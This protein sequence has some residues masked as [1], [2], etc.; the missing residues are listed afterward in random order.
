VHME[1]LSKRFRRTS[2]FSLFLTAMVLSFG[3]NLTSDP[4]TRALS[5]FSA[6]M[7]QSI[8]R[9]STGKRL[10]FS[11]DNPSGVASALNLS[12][13]LRRY[14]AIKDGVAN[15]AGLVQVQIGALTDIHRLLTRAEV[16]AI[17]NKSPFRWQYQAPSKG[18][19]TSASGN[20]NPNF[21]SGDEAS[22]D[23]LFE[24]PSASQDYGAS[25]TSLIIDNLEWSTISNDGN[26]S[27]TGVR[28]TMRG[29]L[30]SAFNGVKL[31]S[32]TETEI[33]KV[34]TNIEST[35]SVNV[36]RPGLQGG[37]DGIKGVWD[38]VDGI[39]DATDSRFSSAIGAAKTEVEGVITTKTSDLQMLQDFVEQL[40]A[41][42]STSERSL[43][44]I[45]DTDIAAEAVYKTKS[46]I[47][48]L[49][50]TAMQA[51]ANVRRDMA[52]KLIVS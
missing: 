36:S 13:Q 34:Y 11:Y 15:A 18:S 12:S 26:Q 50:N 5:Q 41:R 31:F 52:L 10:N 2:L 1:A 6:N 29:L 23:F 45:Q 40:A 35:R 39:S 14:Q 37:V 19:S 43:S 48:Y 8:Q 20:S 49:A 25:T 4:S 9:L 16:I 33:M 28:A 46:I 21:G 3:S 47:G 24:A 17:N 30:K 51:Q 7:G 44:R 38:L 32:D 42:T 22:P 27:P